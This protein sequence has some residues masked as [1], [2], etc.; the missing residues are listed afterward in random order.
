MRS[1]QSGTL[2]RILAWQTAGAPAGASPAMAIAP[3]HRTALHRGP[4]VDGDGRRLD[5]AADDVDHAIEELIHFG[6][7]CRARQGDVCGELR[8]R[9]GMNHG[10]P[11]VV[12]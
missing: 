9:V 6:E 11:I 1:R 12:P 5:L 3:P 2:A 10:W 4:P 7:R 8:T